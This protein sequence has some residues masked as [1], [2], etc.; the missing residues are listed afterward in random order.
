M[1]DLN[2]EVLIK[3]IRLFETYA[4]QFESIKRNLE[5]KRDLEFAI[6][7]IPETVKEL[8]GS[9]CEILMAQKDVKEE[10]PKVL[11]EGK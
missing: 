7:S 5:G 9:L 10:L 2:V 11:F 6:N 3:Q 4:K 1:L 8:Q